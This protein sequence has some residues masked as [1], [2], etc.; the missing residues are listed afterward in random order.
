MFEGNCGQIIALAFSVGCFVRTVCSYLT[1]HFLPV[2]FQHS[3]T[4]SQPSTAYTTR[5]HRSQEYLI[6]STTHSV[7]PN[8]HARY[9]PNSTNSINISK[10]NPSGPCHTGKLV[11]TSHRTNP[12][13]QEKGRSIE[14]LHDFRRPAISPKWPKRQRQHGSLV[15]L[16]R[17]WLSRSQTRRIQ[18]RYVAGTSKMQD[19]PQQRHPDRLE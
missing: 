7:S 8:Q 1:K 4:T 11:A 17:Q 15:A 18:P 9:N 16:R 2:V 19:A 14:R 3:L 12:R 10:K 6:Q 13:V 5:C